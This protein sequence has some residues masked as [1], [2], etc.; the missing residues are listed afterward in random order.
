MNCT[1]GCPCPEYDCNLEPT[2]STESTTTTSITTTT[3]AQT[4]TP[5]TPNPN[6]STLLV[7]NSYHSTNQPILIDVNGRVD[8]DFSFDEGEYETAGGC[9]LMIQND[10][11]FFGGHTAKTQILLLDG[12][13][14][15]LEGNLPFTMD[16][17]ACTVSGNK[18]YLGF[19]R[20]ENQRNYLYTSFGPFDEYKRLEAEFDHD[21]AQIAAS[22]SKLLKTSRIEQKR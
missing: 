17:G 11:Y 10:Q 15:K 19:S 5:V 7:L 14:L 13:S 18:M 6:P 2:S 1:G 3:E 21:Y 22:E 12:C 8:Y 16:D 4:T 9:S 20:T